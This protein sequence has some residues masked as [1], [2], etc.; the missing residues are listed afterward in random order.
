LRLLLDEHLSPEIVRQL[1]ARGH[2]VLAVGERHDLR[3]RPDRVHLASQPDQRRVIVTRDLG[4]F[5]PLLAGALRSGT[6]TYGLICVPR[7]FSLSRREIGRLVHALDALLQSHPGDDA[8]VR[9]GGEIWLEDP[10][11]A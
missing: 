6:R 11:K 5:R 3:G 7:R 1:R 2:D 4:D 9:R 8:I 10:P